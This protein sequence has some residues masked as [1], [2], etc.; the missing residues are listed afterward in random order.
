ML[1]HRLAEGFI[2]KVIEGMVVNDAR[3]LVLGDADGV[4]PP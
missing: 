4:A 1:P 3:Q 2:A